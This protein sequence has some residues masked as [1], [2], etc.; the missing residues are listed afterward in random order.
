M[1]PDWSDL[2][3]FLAIARAGTLGKAARLLGLTQPT[4][5]RRLRALEQA[6]GQTLYQRTST[7]FV[8]TDEGRLVLEQAERMETEVLAVN[9]KLAGQRQQLEGLL[10][11]TSSEWFGTYLLSPVLAEFGG[12]HPGVTIELLTDARIYDLVR[13]EA[14]LAFR[15]KRFDTPE[16]VSRRLMHIPYALYGTKAPKGAVLG[17]GAGVRLIM[18]DVALAGMPDSQ[19]LQ[20]ALPHAQVAA[21]SNNREVQARLCSLGAGLAVLPRPVGDTTPGI[22][23]LDIGAAPPGRDIFVGYHRD[24]RKLPRMRALLDLILE[25]LVNI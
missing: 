2:R 17:D 12:R 20:Q 14:D 25:R 10:R 8:L 7:G 4:M 3:I 5:G 13:R 11:I 18:M 22:T 23:A 1:E 16:I 19:W 9:R 24:L 15:F 6:T 21:R